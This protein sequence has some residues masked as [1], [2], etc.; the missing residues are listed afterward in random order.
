MVQHF[1]FCESL[2]CLFLQQLSL[3][4]HVADLP[5][6]H[7]CFEKLTPVMATSKIETNKAESIFLKIIMQW[8]M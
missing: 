3:F 4:S 1:D 5:E 6:R 8:Q 2:E 7:T